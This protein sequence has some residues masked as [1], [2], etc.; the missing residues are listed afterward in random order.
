MAG[1]RFSIPMFDN[2]DVPIATYKE[3]FR[4][5]L[6]FVSV[7]KDNGEMG[8]AFQILM[9]GF[10]YDLAH[11][12]KGPSG[13]WIFFS[14]YNTEEAHTMLEVEASQN[15]KDFIAAINW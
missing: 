6:S 8:I 2:Q 1:T 3:N 12:G 15:D 9:P 5:M 14:T 10:D 4:G 7:N 13:D 11:A